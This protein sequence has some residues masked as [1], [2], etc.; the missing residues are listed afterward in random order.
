MKYPFPPDEY[1]FE[2]FCMLL[3]RK[4]WKTEQV[5]RFGT[6]GQGQYGVDILDYSGGDHLRAA[7]CKYHKLGVKLTAQDIVAEVELAT[8]FPQTISSY[9]FLTTAERSTKCQLA[10]LKL[11]KAHQKSGLFS[12]SLLTWESL[13]LIVDEYPELQERLVTAPIFS[14]AKALLKG[15]EVILATIESKSLVPLTDNGDVPIDAEITEARSAIEKHQYSLGRLTPGNVRTSKWDRC[16]PYQRFR[17]LSNLSA[18]FF[19]EGR[20]EEAGRNLIQAATE[21]PSNSLAA[22]T[23]AQGTEL[24]G[25]T[26]RAFELATAVLRATPSDCKAAAIV[27]RTSPSAIPWGDVVARIPTSA[28][29]GEV[30]AAFATRAL[31]FGL[32]SVAASYARQATEKLPEWPIG[33]LLLGDALFRSQVD[34]FSNPVTIDRT[35]DHESLRGAEEAL[36]KALDI[37]ATADRR[38]AQSDALVIRSKVRDILGNKKG[39]GVDVDAAYLLD[40]TRPNVLWIKANTLIDKGD[41]DGA[42]DCL[43]Q[44]IAGGGDRVASLVS[45]HHSPAGPTLQNLRQEALELWR[46]L[47]HDRGAQYQEDAALSALRDLIT[48]GDITGATT[49]VSELESCVALAFY[50]VLLSTLALRSL[51]A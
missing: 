43:R 36:T 51:S 3:L 17:L 12:V 49:F 22:A 31:E 30:A 24:L 9:Y 19:H 16:R 45:L 46:M 48:N 11:N 13:E 38:D 39:A 35:I 41:P 7:Q 10:V 47:A 25:D 2:D 8:S 28:I 15:Q 20:Y 42:I 37:S 23:E 18:T 29:D 5:D 44:A 4:L 1:A 26:D 32:F 27:V 6:R 34:K 40:P 50:D 21:D 33:W 14:V